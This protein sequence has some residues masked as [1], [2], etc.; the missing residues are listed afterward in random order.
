MFC[1]KLYSHD[2]LQQICKSDPAVQNKKYDRPFS[3]FSSPFWQQA[4]GA[5]LSFLKKEGGRQ[6]LPPASI[7]AL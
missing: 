7:A 6:S 1:F 2:F 5:G 3:C 4:E